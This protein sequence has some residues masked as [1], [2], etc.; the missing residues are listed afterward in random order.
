METR[1]KADY[2]DNMFDLGINTNDFDKSSYPTKLLRI[3]A[4]GIC[5]QILRRFSDSLTKFVALTVQWPDNFIPVE[6]R[7]WN[8]V[9]GWAACKPR[10]PEYIS[11]P[12]GGSLRPNTEALPAVRVVRRP[13]AAV[14]KRLSVEVVVEAPERITRFAM[15]RGRTVGHHQTIDGKKLG[16]QYL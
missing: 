16:F 15:G 8:A 3:T 5:L 2:D 14:A 4:P 12:A 1:K 13:R 9:H 7:H 6:T 11:F 10:W